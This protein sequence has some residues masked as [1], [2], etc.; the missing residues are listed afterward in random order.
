MSKNEI[1]FDEYEV[2]I[3]LDMEDGSEIECVPTESFSFNDQDYV[4]LMPLNGPDAGSGQVYLYRYHVN[5][6]EEME[7]EYIESDEEYEA[8]ADAYDELL[9]E[10]E[11]EE[12]LKD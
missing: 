10:E 12:L 5:E 11:Y 9:D 4:A 7:I 2:T 8:V 1:N 3:T 6:L